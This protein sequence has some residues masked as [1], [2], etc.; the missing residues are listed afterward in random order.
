MQ[1]GSVHSQTLG[2]SRGHG[3]PSPSSAQ[4]LPT[5]VELLASQSKSMSCIARTMEL[6]TKGKGA[7]LS[8]KMDIKPE[9]RK[10]ARIANLKHAKSLGAITEAKFKS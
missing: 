3:S 2:G 10:G 9:K 1:N 4:K 5:K 7:L 6:R 8:I